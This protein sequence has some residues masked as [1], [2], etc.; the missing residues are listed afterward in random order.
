MRL[1]RERALVEGSHTNMTEGDTERTVTG[2]RLTVTEA[3]DAMGISSEAVRTRIQRGTL[4][5][6]RESGRL[7]VLF[8]IDRTQSNADRT[9]NQ[10]ALVDELR[11]R[12]AFLEGQ[13]KIR[14]EDNW[15]KNHLLAAALERTPALEPP[16][17]PESAPEPV[18][19]T[20]HTR[21]RRRPQSRSHGGAGCS[22]A[23]LLLNGFLRSSC[24][25][26]R[27]PTPIRARI[28]S[29]RWAIVAVEGISSER[30]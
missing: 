5:S 8:D 28:L 3:A 15:R 14:T 7:F 9:G 22:V 25:A 17:E 18:P 11:D 4:R 20:E 30:V 29:L 24:L 27:C 26:K 13:L 12:V 21:N 2:H 19:S 23:E 6:V 16:G 1:I 10:T